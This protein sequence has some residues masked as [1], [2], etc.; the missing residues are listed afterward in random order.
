MTII[1][2]MLAHF[3]DMPFTSF[4]IQLLPDASLIAFFFDNF[5]ATDVLF[6]NNLRKISYFFTFPAKNLQFPLRISKITL[7]LPMQNERQVGAK[8]NSVGR[9]GQLR[10]T[11]AN[12]GFFHALPARDHLIGFNKVVGLVRNTYII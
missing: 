9:I 3:V 11:L 7:P 12:A 4:S 1:P 8:A 2:A 10:S 6:I 5:L